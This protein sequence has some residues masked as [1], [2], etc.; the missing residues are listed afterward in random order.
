MAVATATTNESLAFRV[1]QFETLTEGLDY[2]ARGQTGINFYSPRGELLEALS[3]GDLRERAHS[4]ALRLTAAGFQRGERFAIVAETHSYFQTFF[5]G[6][7][8]AG[9]I[10]V[11]LPLNIHMGGREAYVARLRGMLQESG[12]RGV[13]GRTDMLPF[14]QEATAGLSIECGTPEDFF[15]L[16]EG[17]GDLQPF[18][19]DGP[20]YIQY[21][22]GSTS[23]P[24]GV[25]ITQKAITNNARGI[26]MHGLQLVEGDRSTSW[27]PLYHDMGLVGFSIAPAMSQISVDYL[28]TASFAR[29]PL[30][31]LKLMTKTGA[32]ISFSP[33]FGYDLCA[34]RGLNGSASEIDLS[35]WRI[36]GVGGEMVRP[37]IL[38]AFSEV[39]DEVGFSSKAFLPSYG[40]AESTL[41][42]SFPEVGIGVEVDMIDR[43]LYESTG[44]AVPVTNGPA[45]NGNG[46]AA[47]K[48]KA[49]SR[50]FVFCGRGLPGHR[51]EIRDEHENRMPDRCVGRVMVKGPSVMAGYFEDPGRTA[52]TMTEDGWLD[53]GDLGYS[54]DGNL[55]ITGRKKDLI[56]QNGR[57]IWPQDIEWALESI[58]HLKSGSIACFAVEADEGDSEVIVVAE[59]RLSDEEARGDLAKEIVSRVYRTSGVHA[60]VLLVPTRSLKFTSSG[61]LSR[62]AV[63]ADYLSGA[64]NILNNEEGDFPAPQ[65]ILRVEGGAKA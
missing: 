31:W 23:A 47:P 10:P 42:V 63:K 57:N 30:V 14:L 44:R 52:E 3:Y 19:K 58:E 16:P 39:Y 11:P 38:S 41:A 56:I 27:L 1:A 43:T 6:C 53:T 64:L 24:R 12:A 48:E 40:L 45:T 20:C 59:C 32:T 37:E 46:T 61:K 60:R 8:Y 29:R 33:T 17:A 15:A 51:L 49:R 65:A 36:A 4:L 55:V 5:Y 26:G 2:A 25:F 9:L 34:R 54:V 62:A 28:S 18:D 50:G 35:S 13:V 21:S 7:L 22:S